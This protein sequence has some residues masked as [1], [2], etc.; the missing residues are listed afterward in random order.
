MGGGEAQ[1]CKVHRL[2]GG[3]LCRGHLHSPGWR[4][5]LG[6]QVVVGAPS[7]KLRTLGVRGRVL[8]I[9]GAGE[10]FVVRCGTFHGILG[11]YPQGAGSLPPPAQL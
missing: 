3:G 11:L 2:R 7:D 9:F 5:W 8:L 4:L 6:V 10:F 1:V